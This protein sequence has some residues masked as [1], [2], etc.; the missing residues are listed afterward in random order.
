MNTA[1]NTTLAAMEAA[2]L[3]SRSLLVR[4]TVCHPSGT[5]RDESEARAVES[6]ASADAGSV[7]VSRRLWPKGAMK[8]ITTSGSQ[9]RALVRDWSLPWRDGWSVIPTRDFPAYQKAMRKIISEHEAAVDLFVS[10]YESDYNAGLP[11]ARARL[12]SLFESKLFP[13]PQDLRDSMQI[14][15]ESAPIDSG[16]DSRIDLPDDVKTELDRQGKEAMEAAAESAMRSLWLSVSEPL[17]ALMEKMAS[18]EGFEV[19][20]FTA[21]IDACDRAA[22]LNIASDPRLT[23]LV[24]KARA[25][26][27]AMDHEAIRK[28]VI[29]RK[30][31]EN[32][33]RDLCEEAG[34]EVTHRVPEVR[35]TT[36]PVAVHYPETQSEEVIPQALQDKVDDAQEEGWLSSLV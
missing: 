22:R 1:S 16:F 23:A 11:Q 8:P 18:G 35:D 10:M 26:V 12:G 9:A 2:N 20:R 32:A 4:V 33:A 28:D 7:G 34:G 24:E 15:P 31:A 29:I 30:F 14:K 5:R 17:R 13:S 6:K 25:V 21:V 36:P 27:G 19:T 3:R